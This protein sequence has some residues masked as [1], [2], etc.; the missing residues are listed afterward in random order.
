MNNNKKSFTN[1]KNDT[2][3]LTDTNNE[4]SSSWDKNSSN[5]SIS[6]TGDVYEM[7]FVVLEKHHIKDISH[8]LSVSVAESVTAGAL[9]NTICSEPGSSK[10]F[11][12]GIVAY[13]M[14]TQKILLNVDAEYAEK[15]NFANPFTTYTMAK[16]VTK[17]FKSRI[18]L[19]TTGFSLPFYREED[20]ENCKC[21]ID[22][23]TPYAYICLYDS[24][25]DR[26]KIYKI[27]NDDYNV[28][29]NQ[30]IQRAQMQSKVA[31]ECKKLFE[32]Y[33]LNIK[34]TT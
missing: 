2:N 32:D 30:K 22:V 31:L 25:D 3:D 17:L 33:C 6:P 34:N 12:G 13:N 29:G 20:L 18:G 16:N 15:N 23:K 7:K 5:S 9:S 1:S 10:F 27:I 14:E 26:H 4:Q 8:F 21:E 11:L 24:K 28:G 19:S